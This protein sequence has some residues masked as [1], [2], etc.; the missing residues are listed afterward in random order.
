MPLRP[1][2]AVPTD[3]RDFTR[4]ALE[5]LEGFVA[6]DIADGS[7][8][9]AK[10]RTSAANSI[11]GRAANTSGVP[12]DIAVGTAGHFLVNRGGTLQGDVLLDADIPATIARDTEVSAAIAALNLSSGTYTPSLT[13]VANLDASTTHVCQYMRVGSTVTVSGYVEVNATAGAATQLGISLPVA[14]N[15]L[16]IEDCAGTAACPDIAGMSAAIVADAANNRAEMQW[17]AT[18]LNNRSMFFSFTY[19]VN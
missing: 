5:A 14:S 7:I 2:A 11:I 19:R 16:N 3:I 12:A 4:W 18:D 9:D 8:T 13:N 10:L 17:I 1:P 6:D 15:L